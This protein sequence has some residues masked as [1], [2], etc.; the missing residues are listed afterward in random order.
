VLTLFRSTS[1]HRPKPT[2][3]TEQYCKGER[4][5]GLAVS[6]QGIFVILSGKQGACTPTSTETGILAGYFSGLGHQGAHFPVIRSI[7]ELDAHF[8]DANHWEQGRHSQDQGRMN[9]VAMAATKGAGPP[10]WN[11]LHD[12]D[13]SAIYQPS[14]SLGH[15][16]GCR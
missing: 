3:L 7:R 1:E 8:R 12:A 10:G 13:A 15:L 16:P 6:E 9:L 14:P 11:H 4:K 2:S 5:L